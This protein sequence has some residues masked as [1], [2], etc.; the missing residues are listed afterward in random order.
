MLI[1]PCTHLRIISK[2]GQPALIRFTQFNLSRELGYPQIWLYSVSG[3][4]GGRAEGPVAGCVHGV[5]EQ[6]S[7]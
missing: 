6:L 2:R 4:S 1:N 7:L 3:S 5:S